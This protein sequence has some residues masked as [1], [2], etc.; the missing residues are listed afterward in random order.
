VRPLRAISQKNPHR[1]LDGP[2]AGGDIRRLA[3][4]PGSICGRIR[5]RVLRR[6]RLAG[7]TA[8]ACLL[9]VPNRWPSSC[10]TRICNPEVSAS[11]SCL[12]TDT[13][14]EVNP[15]AQANVYAALTEL[16]HYAERRG[17]VSSTPPTTSTRCHRDPH[18]PFSQMFSCRGRPQGWGVK[19]LP[20]FRDFTDPQGDCFRIVVPPAS[21]PTPDPSKGECGVANRSG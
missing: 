14:G 8:A 10:T 9:D 1:P 20:A 13:T 2:G 6:S 4:G 17:R 12:R 5:P 21:R 15:Q 7:G 19:S 16:N 3:P 11:C 18:P